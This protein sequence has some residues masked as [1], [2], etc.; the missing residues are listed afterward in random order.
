MSKRVLRSS[1]SRNP[2]ALEPSLTGLSE[3]LVEHIPSF[4]TP[5]YLSS[6]LATSKSLSSSFW[7]TRE[8]EAH[9]LAVRLMQLALRRQL[10]ETLKHV[11]SRKDDRPSFTLD[12]LFPEVEREEDFDFHFDFQG[13]PQ[14]LLSGSCAVQAALGRMFDDPDAKIDIDIF[15]TWQSALLVRQRLVERCG[16]MCGGVD[17][18]HYNPHGELENF[19]DHKFSKVHH[20]ELFA[21]RPTDRDDED[22]GG[23]PRSSDAYYQQEL[24][25]GEEMVEYEYQDGNICQYLVG[26]PG[27]SAG[28]K[29]PYDYDLQDGKGSVCFVQLI[30]D[31]PGMGNAREL[32][33]YYDLEMCTCH[34][35]GREF[36]V[37]NPQDTFAGRTAMTHERR[38]LVET[39]FDPDMQHE[40]EEFE[41]KYE[42]GTR[43]CTLIA[44][45]QKYHARG[46]KI[47]DPQR[48]FE[49]ENQV[50]R[51]AEE[52]IE[53]HVR[54][55]DPG[56]F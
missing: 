24:E 5:P 28:G 21:G 46:I 18:D 2:L 20:V 32:L 15:C 11:T 25:W 26:M 41:A 44:R 29:F 42:D 14:V 37:P 31:Q 7:A 23:E 1:A 19:G 38:Q 3:E 13:R 47:V 36:F 54:G 40:K 39:F 6:F 30:I 50:S 10:D 45:M 51:V 9:P 55:V 43:A 12:D 4:L 33:D 56:Q 34:F 52:R 22:C 48:F 53:R 16:L 49:V 27:G 8:G 35:Y 17:T